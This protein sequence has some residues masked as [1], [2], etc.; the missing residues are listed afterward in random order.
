MASQL[1]PGCNP[2]SSA[3]SSIGALGSLVVGYGED[4]DPSKHVAAFSRP[5][6]RSDAIPAAAKIVAPTKDPDYG[7]AFVNRS[8]LL[9]GDGGSGSIYAIPVEYSD[10]G[11]CVLVNHGGQSYSWCGGGFGYSETAVRKAG[12]CRGGTLEIVG[13]VPNGVVRVEVFVNR[14]RHDVP[15]ENNAFLYESGSSDDNGNAYVLIYR[16]GKRMLTYHPFDWKP[17]AALIGKSP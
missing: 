17:P 1:K 12:Q 5:R 16:S 3:L 14:H 15:V 8:R 4:G 6:R 2:A 10:Q 9:L 11:L 7:Q 13:I